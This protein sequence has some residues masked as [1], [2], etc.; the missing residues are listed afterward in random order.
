M[1]KHNLYGNQV[2]GIFSEGQCRP[3]WHQKNLKYNGFFALA[4]K[5]KKK[6]KGA[7]SLN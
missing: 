4:G 1:I 6:I 2:R 3:T 5:K 7:I